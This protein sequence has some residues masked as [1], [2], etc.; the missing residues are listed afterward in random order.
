MFEIHFLYYAKNIK[1]QYRFNKECF[2][3]S[4]NACV[5]FLKFQNTFSTLKKIWNKKIHFYL[6]CFWALVNW[7]SLSSERTSLTSVSWP[8]V[9]GFGWGYASVEELMVVASGWGYASGEELMV[10]ASGWGYASG[11]ELMVVASGWGYASEEEL[12]VVAPGWG[13]E[14]GE[15]LMVVWKSEIKL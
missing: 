14:S 13:Y 3:Y 5:F 9:T 8:E 15:E 10:V 1:F 11:E 4:L 2:L 12:M 7:R 6:P